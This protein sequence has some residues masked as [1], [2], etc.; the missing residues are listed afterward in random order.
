MTVVA[1]GTEETRFDG[2]P[3]MDFP[4]E[5]DAGAG[6]CARARRPASLPSGRWEHGRGRGLSSG[7]APAGYHPTRRL[8]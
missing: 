7:F 3:G 1:P 4:G 8:L 2:L 5:P 6:G